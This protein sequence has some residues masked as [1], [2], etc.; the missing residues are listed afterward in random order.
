M[1]KRVHDIVVVQ[2]PRAMNYHAVFVPLLGSEYGVFGGLV[3]TDRHTGGRTVADGDAGSRQADLHHMACEVAGRVRVLLVS[4]SNVAGGCVIVRPENGRAATTAGGSHQ[5]RN[6]IF[7]FVI[8]DRLRRLDHDLHLQ[9][10]LGKAQLI[11]EVFQ[12]LDACGNLRRG[13][14]LRQ[15]DD[16]MVWQFAPCLLGQTGQKQV[17]STNRAG[18]ALIGKRLDA[19]TDKGR[20][21]ILAHPFGDFICGRDGMRVFLIVGTISIAVLEIDPVILDRLRLQLLHNPVV[22]RVSQPGG[23]FGFAHQIGVGLQHAGQI[24]QFGG[25]RR[26]RIGAR[27]TQ[28]T[29]ENAVS[30]RIGFQSIERNLTQLGG[31]SGLE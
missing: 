23:L 10:I 22:H 9:R 12:N 26:Q 15:S 27:H 18:L 19:D 7:S 17:E 20:Q 14:N 8:N 31:K 1:G 3:G 11:F 21:N 28:R 5:Q 13:V 6:R 2:F 29:G 25:I 24:R 4:G 16:E 30:G